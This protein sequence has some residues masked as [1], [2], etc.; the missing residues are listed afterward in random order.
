MI[1]AV[2]SVVWVELQHLKPLPESHLLCCSETISGYI[3]PQ[4]EL[5]YHH[6]TAECL[7][8]ITWTNRRV[9]MGFQE[10]DN[11]LLVLTPYLPKGFYTDPSIFYRQVAA[12]PNESYGITTHTFFANSGKHLYI[13]YLLNYFLSFLFKKQKAKTKAILLY[14]VFR[15]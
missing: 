12:S 2:L 13:T 4:I 3:N 1:T 7:V 9:G 14:R 6:N 10:A 8:S 15:Y 11:L 5:L